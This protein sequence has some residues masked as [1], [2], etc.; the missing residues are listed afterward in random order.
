[1]KLKEQKQAMRRMAYDARSAQKNKDEVSTIIC[2]TFIALDDYQRSKIAMW[3]ID[4]R[5]EVRTQKDLREELKKAQR[6]IIVPYCTVSENGNNIIGLW[7]LENI[8]ELHVGKWKILEPPRDSWDDP[9]KT[10]A[11]EELD[12]IIV[13]GVGFD[14][15]GGRIGNGHGYYDHLLEKAR[16]DC[17]LVAICYENQIFDKIIMGASDVYMDL[18]ITEKSVYKGRGR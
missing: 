16:L 10:V 12:V 7:H 9:N 13:P 14:R 18:V 5:S 6:K 1:M 11:P 4:C 3:Y 2:N 15:D 8:D 17:K